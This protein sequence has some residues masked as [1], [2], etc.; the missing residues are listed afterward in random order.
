VAGA[1]Y[2][3]TFDLAL[4]GAG[5]DVFLAPSWDDDGDG[6]EFR[7]FFGLDNGV[8]SDRFGDPSSNSGPVQFMQFQET[9]T[10]STTSTDLFFHGTDNGGAILLANVSLTQNSAAPEPASFFL[11]A[12]GFMISSITIRRMTGRKRSPGI[13]SHQ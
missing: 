9:V 5:S 4:V 13:T 11:L 10:A 1:Q 7:E 3:L 12:M 2:T 6:S 8:Y